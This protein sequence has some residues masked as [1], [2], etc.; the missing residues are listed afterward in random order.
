[1]MYVCMY[2]MVWD[3]QAWDDECVQRY[4]DEDRADVQADAPG[5]LERVQVELQ[6]G[7]AG[8]PAGWVDYPS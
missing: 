3:M 2:G 5:P 8:R 4:S 6:Q 1:M 7:A